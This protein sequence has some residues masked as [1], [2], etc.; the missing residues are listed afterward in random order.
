MLNTRKYIS[1]FKVSCRPAT[2][3]T[4]QGDR[5]YKSKINISNIKGQETV[6]V[7]N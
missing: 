5:R 1:G 4:D 7:M 2:K 6:N 3:T